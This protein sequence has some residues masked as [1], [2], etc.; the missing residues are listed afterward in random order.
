MSSSFKYSFL[1]LLLTAGLAAAD[2]GDYTV[3]RIKKD[4]P[5]DLPV[6]TQKLLDTNAVQFATKDGKAIADIWFDKQIPVTKD[7]KVS[8]KEITPSTIVGA[9]RF[10]KAWKDFRNQNIKPGVYTMRYAV[11]PQDGDHMGTAPYPTFIVL[12]AAKFDPKTGP[13]EFKEMC[14]RSAA[15]INTTHPAVFLLFPSEKAAAQPKLE[16][17]PNDRI[18]LSIQ[19]D[20]AAGGK[21]SNAKLG[22]GMTLVGH[23]AE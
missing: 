22:I 7:G 5:K 12:I 10:D 14:E 8:Y 11:Q 1:F 4:V 16:S 20:V 15:S 9:I 23:A 19:R 6:A 18:I 2:T 21:K 17:R 3:K 13:Y